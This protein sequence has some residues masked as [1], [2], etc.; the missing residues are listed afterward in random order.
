MQFKLCNLKSPKS[1]KH[2][3]KVMGD[4]EYMFC[5]CCC[6]E[7]GK[8]CDGSILRLAT[9]NGNN[10]FIH[11]EYNKEIDF[12]GLMTIL[13]TTLSVLDFSGIKDI[14]QGKG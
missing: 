3:V 5:N 11:H 1:C 6:E 7:A 4:R 12:L 10:Y 14:M 9:K 8:C 2:Q 13:N